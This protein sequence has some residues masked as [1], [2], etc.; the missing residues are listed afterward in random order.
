[1]F[2]TYNDCVFKLSNLKYITAGHT[3]LYSNISI[4]VNAQNRTDQYIKI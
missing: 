3:R 2:A 1:M 4:P